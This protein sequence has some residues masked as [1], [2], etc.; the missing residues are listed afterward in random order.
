M[1]T[2]DPF[3]IDAVPRRVMHLIFLVD[4]SGSMS[5]A[6]IASLNT[7]VREA[8]NDVGEISR[9]NSDAQM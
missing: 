5:G 9:N 3:A 4:T 1:T 6:K 7:A 8:L 2:N